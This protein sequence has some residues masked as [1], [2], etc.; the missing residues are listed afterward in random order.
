MRTAR[1]DSILRT[2]AFNSIVR[3]ACDE[4]VGEVGE[5]SS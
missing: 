2:A 5:G 1:E 3:A 4:G